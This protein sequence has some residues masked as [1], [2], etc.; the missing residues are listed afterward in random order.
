M[1]VIFFLFELITGEDSFTGIDNDDKI[2]GINM[3]S[4]NRVYAYRAEYGRLPLATR[5]S[6]LPA[7]SMTHHFFS[8]S[9]GL[10]I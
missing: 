6:G 5:P 3:G 4:K 1:V 7:A 2:P 8:T 9:A 10:A